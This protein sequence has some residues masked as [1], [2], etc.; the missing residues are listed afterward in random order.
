MAITKT[1]EIDVNSQAAQ[2]DLNK[3][4][5][6]FDVLGKEAT[7]SIKNIEKGVESTE[8]STKSLSQ[9]F[10]GVGLAIKAMG[11]GLVLEAFNI[12][13]DLFMSNQVIADKFGAAFKTLSI[14]FN[15]FFN[16][17]N[18][19]ADGIVSFFK[20][21]FENPVESLKNFGKLIQEN[22]IERFNSAIEVAGFMADALK[23][24][25]EGDFEAALDSVKEAGKEMIDVFTGVDDTV[26][27]VGELADAAAKYASETW[28]A[29]EALQA[30]ENA[31]KRAVAIQA[32]LVE[33]YDRQAEKLRQIRDNDL[34]SI[35]ERIKANEDLG[36]VLEKQEQAMLAQANLQVQAAQ[37]Q[38]NL[39]KTIENEVAL[40][41]ARNNVKAVE[42]QIEGFRSEQ[43][44]NR[45]SLE[46]ESLDLT[47]SKTQAESE[48][49]TNQKLFDA[50]RLK[51][52][53]KKLQAQKE[54][55]ENQRVIE[56]ER[57]KSNI[58]LYKQGTQARLDAE[59]EYN[60]KKQELDNAVIAKQDEIDAN[61]LN[62][63]LEKKQL[64]INNE[65]LSFEERLN[66]L[67]ERER[68][69]TEATNLSESERTR[70]L[71]ENADEQIAIEKAV[72]DQKLALQNQNIDSTIAGIGVLKGIFEKNKAIQKG[73][74]VAE[75][76]VG[77]AK[78]II[79]TQAAN[80]RAALELGPYV[81][82]AYITAN[83]ISA[84][85]GI[86]ANIASTVKALSA[87]GGG[88]GGGSAPANG[89]G[90][91]APAPSFNVVGNSGVN[92]IA[93]TLG[94]QQP[95]QA[96][97]VANNV[98]TQQSLDRNIVNNASLG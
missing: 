42:A 71:K 90:A 30:Q 63:Q 69:I 46:K 36:K 1:I 2:K 56:L 59:N 31:A 8:K 98:T 43:I 75:S 70:L 61:N 10:K 5:N 95:V 9:G 91:Q 21:I 6:Q 73:L 58:D 26:G 84:G 80:A 38:Y 81:A 20:N 67:N 64:D 33:Q 35:D 27:K 12:L 54:A 72:A 96:Y 87:L 11:I 23:K 50:E 93:Q 82:P 65:K 68:L 34:I 97:V 25:F 40:I 62:K 79:N 51:D 4:I 15:D 37:N 19:N 53:D 55:L 41:D 94:N 16:Y 92:Q 44:A 77:I 83:N 7:E 29:A 60:A 76:A 17:I 45:I 86:A 3:V 52:E 32:G 14:M 78:I 47:K 49:A 28:N 85:V 18:K 48:L 22:I 39:N 66:A 57:L 13:K 89:G 88:G 24:L 74:I